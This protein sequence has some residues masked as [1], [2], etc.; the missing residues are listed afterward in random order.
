M[1]CEASALKG[2]LP[3]KCSEEGLLATA[4]Q[5]SMVFHI[6]ILCSFIRF[7]DYLQPFYRRSLL[8]PFGEVGRGRSY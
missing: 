2:T 3:L 4:R 7:S 5:G 1:L 8:L 6:S